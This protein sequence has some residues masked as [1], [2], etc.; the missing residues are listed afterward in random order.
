MQMFLDGLLAQYPSTMKV[1]LVIGLARVF[2]KP[3]MSFLRQVI[4]LTE[5]KKDDTILKK[6]E[7][8]AIFKMVLYVLDWSLSVKLRQE[9]KS[10]P[11]K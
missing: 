2:M 5:T 9:N 11:S 4:T 6:I 7:E 3:T 8:N 1:V 10:K